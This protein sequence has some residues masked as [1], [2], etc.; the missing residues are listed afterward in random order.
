MVLHVCIRV[1][2]FVCLKLTEPHGARKGQ[3]SHCYSAA[4]SI[5]V[6][7]HAVVAI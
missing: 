4:K 6:N 1:R 5:L 3:L 2:V 7:M